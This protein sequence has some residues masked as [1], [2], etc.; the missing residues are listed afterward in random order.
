MSRAVVNFIEKGPESVPYHR[1]HITEIDGDIPI[2]SIGDSVFLRHQL[3]RVVDVTHDYPRKAY[4]GGEWDFLA[5]IWVTV[6][7]DEDEEV[8]E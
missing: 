8:E 6:T 7:P 2:P 5:H 4:G 1:K 3:Y